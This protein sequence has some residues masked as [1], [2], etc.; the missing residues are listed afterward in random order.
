MSGLLQLFLRSNTVATS[1]GIREGRQWD[2][3]H[4]IRI[5]GPNELGM[6][7]HLLDPVTG[8]RSQRV[9]SSRANSR[10]SLVGAEK[11]RVI[12]MESLNTS[13]TLTNNQFSPKEYEISDLPSR[14]CTTAVCKA[15]HARAPSYSLFPPE[16]SSPNKI[17]QPTSVYDISDL[18]P[19]PVIHYIG[20]PRH[21]RDSSIAS[22]AT[23]QIGLRISH[24]PSPAGGD[25]NAMPL[26]STTYKFSPK[27]PTSTLPSTSYAT[28]PASLPSTTYA[29]G[30]NPFLPPAARTPPPPSPLKSQTNVPATPQAT[31]TLTLLPQSPRRPTPL[32]STPTKSLSSPTQSLIN[33]TLP[34]TPRDFLPKL[35]T[36]HPPQLARQSTT[37]L[38]P[39]VYSPE[40]KIKTSGLVEV[41]GAPVSATLPNSGLAGRGGLASPMSPPKRSMS[42]GNPTSQQQAKGDWI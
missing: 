29:S 27:A 33:K 16:G 26:P 40:K 32:S 30:S 1:F 12:S 31:T 9:L 14:P 41:R 20:G 2:R 3:K 11:G 17:Q 36:A 19:P 35:E 23:V 5:F 10:A 6:R 42:G 25:M 28:A 18:A 13:P 21:R 15:R 7:S 39:A 34:P 8:P 38:T 22:S 37:Q 24:A 4:Q